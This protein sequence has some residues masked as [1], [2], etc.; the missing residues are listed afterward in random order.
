MDFRTFRSTFVEKYHVPPPVM[1]CTGRIQRILDLGANVGF[2]AADLA[3]SFPDSTVVAVEMDPDNFSQAEMNTRA[4]GERVRC[5]N[6][7]AWIHDGGVRYASG[8]DCDAYRVAEG[9]ADPCI[10]ARSKT[11]D[12]LIDELPGQ[13]ADFV[14]IDVEGA[15]S[16]LLSDENSAWLARVASL[17]VE[18]H[19]GPV[20]LARL[21]EALERSGFVVRKS[22]SR[23]VS[24]WAWRPSKLVCCGRREAPETLSMIRSGL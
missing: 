6:A 17:N 19:E 2:T 12:Q 20:V 22:S 15:E 24:L 4:F 18:V 5:V 7:A 1:T 13:R 9:G 14:K 16:V 3:A 21:V 11:V 10:A 8:V 23:G